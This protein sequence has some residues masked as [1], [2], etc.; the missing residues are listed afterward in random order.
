[1]RIS[2]DDIFDYSRISLYKKEI[3]H[4]A[5]DKQVSDTGVQIKKQSLT[6]QTADAKAEEKTDIK[7]AKKQSPNQTEILNYA[8]N[9]GLA[10]DKELIGMD[11][12]I[13]QLD[14]EKAV[15]SMKKDSVLQGYQYFIGNLSTEDGT[16]TRK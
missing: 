8:R 1:M 6:Q 5:P 16:V 14:V 2:G 7:E 3:P 4:V 13:R 11:V 12:D 9:A 10:A 15:S